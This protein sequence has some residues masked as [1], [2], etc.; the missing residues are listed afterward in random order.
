VTVVVNVTVTFAVNN[1][2]SVVT[3]QCYHNCYFCYSNS[4]FSIDN[5]TDDDAVTVAVTKLLLS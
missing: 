5:D 2:H 1:N 3:L 4:S